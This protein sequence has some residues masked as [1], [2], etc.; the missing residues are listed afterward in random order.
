MERYKNNPKQLLADI[1]GI[2][3][4]DIVGRVTV[5]IEKYA[6]IFYIENADDY[7]RVH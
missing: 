6:I 2:A 1:R 3:V 5:D 7:I 4:S